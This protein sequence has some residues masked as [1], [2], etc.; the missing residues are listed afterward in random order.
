MSNQPSLNPRIREATPADLDAITAVAVRA[1]ESDPLLLW[2]ALHKKP[3]QKLPPKRKEKSLR[4]LRLIEAAEVRSIWQAGGRVTVVVVQPVDASEGEEV[5]VAYTLWLPPHYANAGI[6]DIWKA[7]H[8]DAFPIL[9]VRSLWRAA[10]NFK[11]RVV[12]CYQKQVTKLKIEEH[13]HLEQSGTHPD[14]QGRGY[15]RMLLDAFSH[16]ST[17]P[18]LLEASNDKAYNIYEH[19]G[20]ETFDTLTFGK[21]TANSSGLA[22]KGVDA[23][24][25]PVYMMMK[26][27]SS[28]N[29]PGIKS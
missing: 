17:R 2:I 25:F 1:F 6:V 26:M 24:G 23:I 27:P 11:P 18:L 5:I 16:D 9:G 15:C 8:L 4:A 19:Y 10:F 3:I 20:W 22:T 28:L 14:Y 7:G 21:G 12:A 13:W 29:G